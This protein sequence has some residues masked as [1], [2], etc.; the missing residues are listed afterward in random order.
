MTFVQ[1]TPPPVTPVFDYTSRDYASVYSDLLNRAPL[2]L[3]EWTSTSDSDF[4][5]VLLQM[6]A[7]TCDILNYYS[8]RLAGESFIQ[9]ATQP[10]SILNIASMLDYTPSLSAGSTVNL[11]V[12]I[13][14]T[15]S[16]VVIPAGTQFSTQASATQPAIIFQTLAST[17]I[18]GLAAATPQF[19]ASIAAVQAVTVSNET[20]GTSDGSINQSF[21][22]LFN[23]VSSLSSGGPWVALSVDVGVGP[24]LWTYAANLVDYPSDSFVFTYFIDANGIFYIVFGDNVNGYV[25]PLGSPITCTYQTNS[26]SIGNVG[27]GTIT[28]PVSAIIGLSSVT[29]PA[30]AAGGSDAESLASIQV[31]APA[32]LRALN[33]AI[34]TSDFAVL[35]S[36]ISGVEWASAVEVTYQLVNLYVAPSAGGTPSTTLLST[37]QSYLSGLAMANTTITLYAPTYVGINVTANV[38][39]F[40]SYG[41]TSVQSAIISA[42]QDLLTLSN[43]GFGGRISLGLIYQVINSVPGVN[44][45][46]V[47]SL[48]RSMLA[49]T[50]A[51]LTNGAPYTA[52]PVSPLPQPV[53]SGDTIV[54]TNAIGNT[55]TIT[56][57]GGVAAGATS[58]PATFTAT[59]TFPIGSNVQ[60]TTGVNDAILLN[61]EIPVY[62]S[63][64]TI[65]VTGGVAGS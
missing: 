15:S 7:F 28:Q 49:T 20:V 14:N 25:P 50:T 57:L 29:N 22:L 65:Q 6:F 1:N 23:P 64:V 48:T 58:I 55:Q 30:A 32:S 8:D 40:A 12:T 33:R 39:A 9:T 27:L 5:I 34:T 19:S 46:S 47:T 10:T 41:N 21:P 53:Y 42:L 18:P 62:G 4:G 59:S 16:N 38:T 35:A 13:S 2:Y 44:Y 11:L 61:N 52:I 43:T 17:T 51:V 24:Q 36:Q 60:D 56:A 3:P 45:A 63:A 31:N 26:G 54:L 37:V